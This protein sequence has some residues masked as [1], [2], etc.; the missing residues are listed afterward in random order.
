MK[1][2]NGFG[3]IEKLIGLGDMIL[4]AHQKQQLKLYFPHIKGLSLTIKI[5]LV[6]HLREQEMLSVEEIGL[7][8]E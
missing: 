3:D 5:I 8:I 6:Q 2:L 1:M 7:Q 4:T